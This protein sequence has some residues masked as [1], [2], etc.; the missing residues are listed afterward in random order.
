MNTVFMNSQSSCKLVDQT[1]AVNRLVCQANCE[2]EW[3]PSQLTIPPITTE[4]KYYHWSIAGTSCVRENLMIK[5]LPLVRWSVD[6]FLA[7]NKVKSSC[8]Q[9]RDEHTL[10]KSNDFVWHYLINMRSVAVIL[11]IGSLNQRCPYLPQII[12]IGGFVV[13]LLLLALSYSIFNHNF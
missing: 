12:Y 2:Y 1:T 5:L 11:F 4:C 6:L 7:I 9:A 8:F 13:A 10:H 3:C